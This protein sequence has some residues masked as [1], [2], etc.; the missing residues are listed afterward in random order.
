VQLQEL[1]AEFKHDRARI[2]L[3][4]LYQDYSWILEL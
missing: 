4:L 2:C 3:G 1:W